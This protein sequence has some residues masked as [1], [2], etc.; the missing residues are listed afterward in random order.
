MRI[1]WAVKTSWGLVVSHCAFCW[2]LLTQYRNWRV[3]ERLTVFLQDLTTAV[4]L[5]A[6]VSNLSFSAALKHQAVG[7][8][9]LSEALF[10]LFAIAKLGKLLEGSRVRTKNNAFSRWD[11]DR[12]LDSVSR[13]HSHL[14][15]GWH[16]PVPVGTN[17]EHTLTSLALKGLT[18]EETAFTELRVSF[19]LLVTDLS[20]VFM[21]WSVAETINI[22]VPALF[23]WSENDLATFAA[24]FWPFSFCQC[25]N[26]QLRSRLEPCFIAWR[27]DRDFSISFKLTASCHYEFPEDGCEGALKK[28]IKAVIWAPT[29][30]HLP[31]LIPR[32]K[33]LIRNLLRIWYSQT[34]SG[35]LQKICSIFSTGKS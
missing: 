26:H 23:A 3:V 5:Q 32:F 35:M 17:S 29:R 9:V 24:P 19:L 18:V 8:Q 7:T 28:V 31:F 14:Q 16:Q 1:T 4:V 11:D 2:H 27:L 34:P 25:A 13:G 10:A 12:P 22:P 20:I 33:A 30:L 6:S 15:R 21:G